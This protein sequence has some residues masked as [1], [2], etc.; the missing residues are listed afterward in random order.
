[1]EL[2]M[3]TYKQ[4]THDMQE[5]VLNN[6]VTQADLKVNESIIKKYKR[7]LFRCRLGY[8]E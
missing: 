5:G 2:L 4:F 6:P 3:K 8:S 1:M 7:E